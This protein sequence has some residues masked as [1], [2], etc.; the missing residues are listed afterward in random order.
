VNLGFSFDNGN[1]TI[2]SII[3]NVTKYCS[4]KRLEKFL[5]YFRQRLSFL[6]ASTIPST[7]SPTQPWQLPQHAT[8][9]VEES[10]LDAT[11]PSVGGQRN[12]PPY[13]K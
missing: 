10:R 1:P 2:S 7:A 3:L 6:L 12:A 4:L 11:P 8:L 13:K 5:S 9:H